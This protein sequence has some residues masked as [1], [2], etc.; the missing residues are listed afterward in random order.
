MK[1]IR[2]NCVKVFS[3]VMLIDSSVITNETSSDN[4]LSWDS[5]SHIHLILELEKV[6]DVKI[7]IEDSVEMQNFKMV[8]DCILK[9]MKDKEQDEIV[10]ESLLA[11]MRIRMKG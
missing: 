2:N 11:E 8:Y 1:E 4:L 7:D 10:W 6:F 3:K 5:L 9:N